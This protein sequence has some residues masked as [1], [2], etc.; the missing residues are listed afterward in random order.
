M[1]QLK[2]NGLRFSSR[3]RLVGYGLLML[4]LCDF[5]YILIPPQFMNP[6]WEFQTIGTLVER[7]PVPLL[8]LML[9]FAGSSKFQKKWEI[10]LLKFLSRASLVV[11]VLF[12]LLMP[13]LIVN[14]S[15]LEDQIGA[16][17]SSQLTQQLSGL[18][19]LE[20]KVKKG[21]AEDINDVVARLKGGRLVN[22][23][24]PQELKSKLLSEVTKAK[25]TIK[26]QVEAVGAEQRLNLLK[27]SAKWFLG[28]LIAG[29]LFIYMA[30]L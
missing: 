16:Q 10:I 2:S 22:I 21:T 28:V 5:I 4:S 29:V 20:N 6:I 8:G 23:K 19:Q 25:N 13:L 24:N 17:I 14:S 18:E 11:G 1:A 26:S 3:F 27:K 9:V 30:A 15:R 7:V 12:L